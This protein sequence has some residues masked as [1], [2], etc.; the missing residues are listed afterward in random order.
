VSETK[1]VPEVAA[2]IIVNSTSF[3]SSSEVQDVSTNEDATNSIMMVLIAFFIL[4]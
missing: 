3:T 2:G 1:Y 4:V